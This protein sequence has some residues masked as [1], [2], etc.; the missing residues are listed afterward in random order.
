L[1]WVRV[2]A[3]GRRHG[4]RRYRPTA[5]NAIGTSNELTTSINSQNYLPAVHGM[6]AAYKCEHARRKYF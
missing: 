5:S 3:A 2:A 1:D 4:N 6:P